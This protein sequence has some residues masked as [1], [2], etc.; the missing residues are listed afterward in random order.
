MRSLFSLARLQMHTIAL[1]DAHTE[2]KARL[3][4]QG[5]CLTARLLHIYSEASAWC[6]AWMKVLLAHS[7]AKSALTGLQHT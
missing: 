1:Q 2:V 5:C 4:V 7:Q 3:A 6:C